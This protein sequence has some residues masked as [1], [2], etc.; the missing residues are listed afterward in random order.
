MP[1]AAPCSCS[2]AGGSAL[3]AASAGWFVQRRPLLA[4]GPAWTTSPQQP[5]SSLPSRAAKVFRWGRE[6]W[7]NEFEVDCAADWVNRGGQGQDAERDAHPRAR[8]GKNDRVTT[9]PTASG[10]A[11]AGGSPGSGSGDRP[12]RP[13]STAA[14]GS[15]SPTGALRGSAKSIVLASYKRPGE[16]A[17]RG[18]PRRGLAPRRQRS[19][20]GSTPTPSRSPGTTCRRR[21]R[22]VIHTERRGD[23]AWHRVPPAV[24][25]PGRQGQEAPHGLAADGLGPP[26]R[27]RAAQSWRC[28]Q[29]AAGAKGVLRDPTGKKWSPI[30][31]RLGGVSSELPRGRSRYPTVRFGWPPCHS[32]GSPRHRG[33]GDCSRSSEPPPRRGRRARADQ[34][35]RQ[36][37]ADT[38]VHLPDQRGAVRWGVEAWKDE[39][40]V[41]PLRG[42]RA[43]SAGG[44]VVTR[45]GSCWTLHGLPGLGWVRPRRRPRTR[46][47][48][49]AGERR[50][51]VWEKDRL[52]GHALPV[53]WELVP[54]TGSTGAARRA[55]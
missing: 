32:P 46:R 22:R 10:R 50:S 42:D 44:D 6:K 28:D 48:S 49:A 14:T 19:N 26:L 1:Y 31:A 35:C 20:G 33:A 38:L 3:L 21:R 18:A 41:N 4:R 54:P 45:N 24:P 37:P 29:G 8:T 9:S 23:P 11:T 2:V 52:S 15:P 47:R 53:F 17:V 30:D 43:T 13:G 27:A 7:S 55:S 25:P 16:R 39:F 34:G 51:A 5:D 40:E 36:L 12:R